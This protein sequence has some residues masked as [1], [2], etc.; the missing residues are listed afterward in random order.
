MASY[1]DSNLEALPEL[2]EFDKT[3]S[4]FLNDIA[5]KAE[6]WELSS[7]QIDAA[8]KAWNRIQSPPTI[9]KFN[10]KQAEDLIRLCD[11]LLNIQGRYASEFVYQLKQKVHDQGELT[12][13]QYIALIKSLA[14]YKRAIM[15][16][17]F[18]V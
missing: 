15:N 9:L 4:Q 13:K 18:G 6:K 16:R 17:I 7:R 8:K 3:N 5:R 11:M 14:K 1:L 12:E 10:S 2:P